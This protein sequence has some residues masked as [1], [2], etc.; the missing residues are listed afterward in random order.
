MR[1][2]PRRR[3]A[4]RASCSR[5]L[6]RIDCRRRRPRDG[7]PSRRLQWSKLRRMRAVGRRRRRGRGRK[8][9]RP[10]L[11][12]QRPRLSRWRCVRRGDGRRSDASPSHHAHL[13]RP[14][15]TPPT[16]LPLRPLRPPPSRPSISHGHRRLPRWRVPLPPSPLLPL[17]SLALHRRRQRGITQP[18]S[19]RATAWRPP[20]TWCLRLN[21]SATA[22]WD[23]IPA[24]PLHPRGKRERRRQRPDRHYRP[25]ARWLRRPSLAYT[26]HAARQ[27]V[28]Y[29]RG[30]R[31]MRM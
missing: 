12:Q 11:R 29:A 24:W 6:S 5:E 25:R 14:S 28:G 15:P 17:H 26:Q 22:R 3:G 8:R 27:R 31:T 13:P 23:G 4:G 1:Q 18:T 7:A 16:P 30:I 9:K 20:W 19:P 2:Q 21:C 10:R